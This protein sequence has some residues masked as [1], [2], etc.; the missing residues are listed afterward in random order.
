MNAEEKLIK[1]R[2]DLIFDHPFFGM[3]ALKLKI[4]EAEWAQTACTDGRHIYYNSKFIDSLQIPE[5]VGLMAHEVLHCSNGH[6]WRK[7]SREH[8][9]WNIA[10]DF[11]INDILLGTGF[12]LPQGALHDPKWNGLSPEEIYN[13]LPKDGKGKGKDKESNES[14]NNQGP[15]KGQNG[16]DPGGCGG[17][18][19]A[20][21]SQAEKDDLRAEWKS[22]VAA[23]VQMCKQRGNI[24]G[25]LLL[26]IKDIL[27]PPLPWYVLLRDFVE[28]SA[29]NDYNWSRPNRRYLNAGFI[30]PSLY[31]E[32]LNGIVIAIDT[33]GS[34][35]HV[36]DR[37]ANEACAVL[38]SYRTTITVIYCD[39]SIQDVKEY[40]SDEL[41]FKLEMKGGGGTSFK[42]VFEYIDKNGIEPTCLIFLT[43]LEGWFPE[44]EPAY[45]V[46]WVTPNDQ[47]APFGKTIKFN[48][49]EK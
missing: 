40:S 35:Y 3:L 30:L 42:P 23:A 19:Q 27:D 36:L 25:N 7:D 13:K 12:K 2:I 44:K 49:P 21:Q 41:P 1:S 16:S 47:Q 39:Y 11:A 20:P 34:T 38:E 33:S 46:L 24:P 32:E 29:K 6:T 9:K 10:C 14:G 8:N 28:T 17:V 31:S 43:D 15:D 22:A 45:P 26:Q 18:I 37:F 5:I 4:T 48:S